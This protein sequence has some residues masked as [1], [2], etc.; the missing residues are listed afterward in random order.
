MDVIRCDKVDYLTWKW[1][2][3]GESGSSSKENSIR[4]VS[5]LR[6]KD[7]EVAVFV[8]QQDNGVNQDFIIGPCDSTKKTANLPILTHIVGLTYGGESPFQA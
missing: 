2:P 5:S 8:Y 4:Y 1:G 7:S 6:V 3:F